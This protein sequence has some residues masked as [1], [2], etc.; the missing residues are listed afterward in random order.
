LKHALGIAVTLLALALF[1]PAVAHADEVAGGPATHTFFPGSDPSNF[2]FTLVAGPG[3]VVFGGATDSGFLSFLAF[4]L[5]SYGQQP[6]AA[7]VTALGTVQIG[8]QSVP[9][10]QRV[11]VLRNMPDPEQGGALGT[12][13]IIIAFSLGGDTLFR[14]DGFLDQAGHVEFT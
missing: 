7:I 12:R 9:A 1:S 2:H 14:L 11:Y 8:N 3:G 13:V 5:E 10:V 4:S 6:D